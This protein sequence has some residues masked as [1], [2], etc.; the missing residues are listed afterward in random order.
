MKSCEGT[1]NT[2]NPVLFIAGSEP[3]AFFKFKRVFNVM[4]QWLFSKP[5]SKFNGN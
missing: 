3:S 1:E 4:M 5:L 2:L